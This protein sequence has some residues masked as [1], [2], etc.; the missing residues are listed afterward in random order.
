MDDSHIPPEYLNGV[1]HA[2]AAIEAEAL[3]RDLEGPPPP[4]MQAIAYVSEMLYAPLAGEL[5]A[6]I[7]NFLTEKGVLE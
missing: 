5:T 4:N 3:R 7:A 1:F 6:L 2:I